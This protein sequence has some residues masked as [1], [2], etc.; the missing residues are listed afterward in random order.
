MP[1]QVKDDTDES[2]CVKENPSAE[3]NW[4]AANDMTSHS[5]DLKNDVDKEDD[6]FAFIH[7]LKSPEVRVS[8]VLILF[9]SPLLR[10]TSIGLFMSMRLKCRIC[11]LVYVS[12][13][14]FN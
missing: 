10:W 12:R 14:F 6:S 5:I 7:T 9:V 11:D 1:V 2:A 13:N 3:L 4:N 8:V